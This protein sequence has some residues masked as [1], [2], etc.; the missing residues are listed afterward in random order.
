MSTRISVSRGAAREGHRRS[1]FAST[2]SAFLAAATAVTVAA[3]PGDKLWELGL[4]AGIGQSPAVDLD[5]TL[6]ITTYDGKLSAVDG[7]RAIQVVI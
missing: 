7:E 5:G 2:F 4:T 1:W 3:A 6:Y